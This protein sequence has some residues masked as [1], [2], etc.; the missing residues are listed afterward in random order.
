MRI[1]ALSQLVTYNIL[2][3]EP[4]GISAEFES[5]DLRAGIKVWFAGAWWQYFLFYLID[6]PITW[7]ILQYIRLNHV[8]SMYSAQRFLATWRIIY[9]CTE[10]YRVDVFVTLLDFNLEAV[11]PLG[12]LG[13][14]IVMFNESQ[15]STFAL[16]FKLL[17]GKYLFYRWF[18]T[19]VV[20]FYFKIVWWKCCLKVSDNFT[21]FL[22][23][24]KW[25]TCLLILKSTAI[26][27]LKQMPH[28]LKRDTN[29]F[30]PFLGCKWQCQQW[31][32]DQYIA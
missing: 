10:A 22:V 6:S 3:S 16:N 32:V 5:G 7:P 21:Q 27:W 23:N 2:N 8:L 28:G 17:V 25:N 11:N 18:Q 15:C 13:L 4:N 29:Q 31:F 12:H 24:M 19:F 9:I 14:H 1:E 20:Y 30:G 26:I